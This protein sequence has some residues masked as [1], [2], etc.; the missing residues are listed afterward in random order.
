MYDLVGLGIGPF[1]LSL[2]ALADELRDLKT[3]FVDQKE[4][5][6]W[7]PELLF[8]DAT[9][10]TSYLKDLVTSVRPTSPYSFLNYLVQHGLFYA[11]MNTNRTAVTRLE[12][13]R[14]CQWVSRELGESC[15]F[16]TSIQEVH[17]NTKESCFEV[18]TSQGMKLAR[19]L[20]LATGPSPKV[21]QCAQPF[22]GAEVF[23]PKTLSLNRRDLSGKNI[24][25]VGGG[26]TG[27]EIFRNLINGH[28]GHVRSLKLMTSRNN[29]EPLENS[30]F[31][32]EYF[33]PEYVHQ[34]Y[35]LNP[36]VKSELL[37][38]QKMASDGN[39]PE[40]LDLLYNDLYQLKYVRG[41][42]RPI[43]I[44]PAHRLVEMEKS[45]N[46]YKLTFYNEFYQQEHHEEADIVI[47]ATGFE[48]KIPA[49]FEPLLPHLTL[50]SNGS[51]QLNPDFSLQ[52]EYQQTN[53]LFAL[54][55]SRHC[56]GIAEPQ[57]SLMAWRAA[58]ILNSL[59]Q[60][61]AFPVQQGRPIFIRY[62]ADH[63]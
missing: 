13:E 20:S 1:N 16:S 61:E 44:H 33:T 32:N 45:N 39:T 3:C 21:P 30:P 7:H 34:F 50:D 53:R 23:H 25:I 31:I 62:G 27:V 47:L 56:H 58:T 60:N 63:G 54:N 9:M 6:R 15:Q 37:K 59:T 12:F 17:Y 19:H 52:W 26:Q 11:F 38:E 4:E 5:Y 35:G 24:V 8:Q 46:T 10:Q 36:K 14:Y 2:A 41:D 55:F 29:L 22:L 51:F 49:F 48:T 40:Y 18:H 28:F 57:L 42:D 43:T